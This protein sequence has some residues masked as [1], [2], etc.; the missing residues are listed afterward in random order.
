MQILE[1]DLQY[2]Y[3]NLNAFSYIITFVWYFVCM[4]PMYHILPGPEGCQRRVLS[5]PGELELQRMMS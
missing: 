4:F 3:F 2:L 5:D 1:D